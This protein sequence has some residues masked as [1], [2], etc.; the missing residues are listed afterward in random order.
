[1]IIRSA[2]FIVSVASLSQCPGDGLP[3]VAFVGRS[4]VGK[5]SLINKL[6]GRRQL[7]RTSGRPGK[8]Q[9]LN[10]FLIND[11]FYL[12]DLPGYGYAQVSKSLKTAWAPLIDSY[13]GRRQPL[14]AVV[15]LVDLRHPPSKDDRLMQAMLRTTGRS[16]IVAGTKLDKLSRNERV[17]NEKVIRQELPVRPSVPFIPTSAQDGAGMEDLWA[18]LEEAVAGQV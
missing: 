15:Q 2:E 8:T 9:T 6:L 16:C 11:T 10:Y 18:S 14:R 13:L 3:E 1:M 5:S 4:N 12:V 7:A 17:R